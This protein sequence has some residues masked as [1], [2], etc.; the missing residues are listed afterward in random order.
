M[1]VGRIV[2]VADPAKVVLLGSRV[3]GDAREDSDYDLLVIVDAA[4]N[5]RALRSRHPSVLQ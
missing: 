4:P 3:G 5:R 1:I 2:R